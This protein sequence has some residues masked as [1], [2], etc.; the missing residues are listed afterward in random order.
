M[1][2]IVYTILVIGLSLILILLVSIVIGELM[3]R[4]KI[5]NR[6][7]PPLRY[8]RQYKDGYVLTDNR[9]LSQAIQTIY[10]TSDYI[11]Y[12]DNGINGS[13]DRIWTR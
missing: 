2:D 7:R 1:N 10:I 11:E 6:F 8:L 3:S 4:K 13:F 12:S 9:E 5:D